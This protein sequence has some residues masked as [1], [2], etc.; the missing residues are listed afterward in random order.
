MPARY[1]KQFWDETSGDELTDSWGAA[2]YY[3]ETDEQLHV[4]KQLELFENGKILKYDEH[5]TDDAFG[6]LADQPL[7][8]E[9]FA[10]HEIVADEFFAI[11]KETVSQ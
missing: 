7:D 3:F 10:E 2:T 6:S 5:H 4:L 9:E 11:W 1:F 8:M